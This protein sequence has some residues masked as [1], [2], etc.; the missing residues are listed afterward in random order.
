MMVVLMK[1]VLVEKKPFF[2]KY[3]QKTALSGVPYGRI[4][5]EA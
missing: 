3:E 1:I 2:C 4:S 5:A